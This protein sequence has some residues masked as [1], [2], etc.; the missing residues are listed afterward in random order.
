MHGLNGTIDLNIKNES[1]VFPIKPGN[2]TNLL[3]FCGLNGNILE[4]DDVLKS[5]Y[6]MGY[7]EKWLPKTMFPGFFLT[8]LSQFW[9]RY[10]GYV[11]VVH[12]SNG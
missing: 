2:Y 7:H 5:G 10:I 9:L 8:V 11:H 1:Y 3:G 12:V 4:L 6:F